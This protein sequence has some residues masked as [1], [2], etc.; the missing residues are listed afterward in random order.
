MSEI[1]ASVPVVS[2]ENV[3]IG[4]GKGNVL[5]GLFPSRHGKLRF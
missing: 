5:D 3:S 1:V 2:L 4:F